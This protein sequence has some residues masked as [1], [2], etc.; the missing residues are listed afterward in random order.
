MS[1][2]SVLLTGP[3]FYEWFMRRIQLGKQDIRPYIP[4]LFHVMLV[5]VT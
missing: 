4:V 5:S 1:V 3:D 2:S